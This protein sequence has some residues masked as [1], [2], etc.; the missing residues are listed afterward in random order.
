MSN[1]TFGG[2]GN[3]LR[4]VSVMT[5]SESSGTPRAAQARAINSVSISTAAAPDV[6]AVLFRSARD[7]F[8]SRLKNSE[9]SAGKANV[10]AIIRLFA[11]QQ[12]FPIN[13]VLT[14]PRRCAQQ[15][16]SSRL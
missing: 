16:S 7:L 13:P 8:L 9:L 3:G 5:R 1:R 6:R 15:S 12:A 2:A 11:L 14:P 10:I 4:G